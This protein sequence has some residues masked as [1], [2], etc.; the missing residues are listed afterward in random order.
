MNNDN[1]PG[2]EQ[3][4]DGFPLLDGVPAR[5]APRPAMNAE[6]V[7]WVLFAANGSPRI[8]FGDWASATSWALVH[9]FV[10]AD[11][12]PLGAAPVAAE[13][14]AE[15][16]DLAKLLE[17]VIDNIANNWPMRKYSLEEIEIRLR[18]I[19]AEAGKDGAA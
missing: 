13:P 17:G 14:A 18:A 2:N 11:L 7:A 19:V 5:R 4:R 9:G 16:P 1:Q 10:P 6:P 15:A 3:L 8:W 12:V